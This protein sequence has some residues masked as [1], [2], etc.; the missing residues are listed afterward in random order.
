MREIEAEKNRKRQER[1]EE[2]IAQKKEDEDNEGDFEPTQEELDAIEEEIQ[3]EEEPNLDEMKQTKKEELVA[4][5]E[6]EVGKL[7]D[8][9]S[10][11]EE[12]GIPFI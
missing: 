10:Q 1:I 3:P 8:F 12:A 4:N 6:G 2:L 9:V 5:M 11:F 7:E